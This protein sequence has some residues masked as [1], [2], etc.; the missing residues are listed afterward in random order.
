MRI[1][2]IAGVEATEEVRSTR[3]A[4]DAA[5]PEDYRELAALLAHRWAAAEPRPRSI[6]LGGGQ[7]VGKSTLTRVLVAACEHVGLRAAALALDDFYLTKR[8]RRRLAERVH[9][10][11]ETRGPPGT[12]DVARLRAAADA[13]LGGSTPAVVPVFDKGSDDRSGERELSGP[14]DLVIIEGW[15]VGARVLE[16][17]SLET[18][19]NEL[20][21]TNDAEGRWRH[22][23]NEALAREFEPLADA[24]DELV[25]LQVPSLDAV[26]RWRLEQ[27]GE[28]PVGQRM[29]A[30]DVDRFVMH[31]ERVSLAMLAELPGRADVVVEL[32]EAHRV[33]GVRL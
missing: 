12:H 24:L 19:I 10:L 32:D 13:L 6:G 20:E 23:V 7:G 21:R 29:T 28:R 31:Y 17:T 2:D 1:A 8:E 27:E 18:P 26:R 9:P 22:A 30:E 5:A 11:F 33:R 15:C 4:L 25:F 14:F 3:N 16:A